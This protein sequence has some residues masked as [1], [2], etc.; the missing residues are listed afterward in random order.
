MPYFA[1]TWEVGSMRSRAS[2]VVYARNVD[3]ISFRVLAAFLPY[4][5]GQKVLYS[6]YCRVAVTFGVLK[7]S[8]CG[9]RPLL[10]PG[11]VSRVCKVSIVDTHVS[12]R[13][14][15]LP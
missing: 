8:G 1:E 15:T 2:S 10:R 9:W 13:R 14:I 3:V 4:Y 5:R 11:A 7:R 12:V 6:I